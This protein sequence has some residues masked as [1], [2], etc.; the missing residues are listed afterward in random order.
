MNEPSHRLDSSPFSGTAGG[1]AMAT[2]ERPELHPHS[3]FQAAERRKRMRFPLSMGHRKAALIAADFALL[4][5]SLLI[6]IQLAL[7]FGRTQIDANPDPFVVGWY[8]II[9]LAVGSATDIYNPNRITN[10][11]DN[12]VNVTKALLITSAAYFLLPLPTNSLLPRAAVL[13]ATLVAVILLGSWR[14]LVPALVGI[15]NFRRRVIIVGAGTS[16]RMIARVIKT[17]PGCDIVGFVDDDPSKRIGKVEGLAVLGGHGD[18]VRVAAEKDASEIV[19]AINGPMRAELVQSVLTCAEWGIPVLQMQETFEQITGRIPVEHVGDRW[20]V[21]LPINRDMRTAYHFT[22][23][24][25]DLLVSLIGI[26]L[27]APLFPFVAAAIKLDS[28]GPIFYKQLRLGLQGRPFYVWKLRTMIDNAEEKT[29]P[30]FAQKK[31]WRVTRV[32]RFLR[33]SHLDE[34]PQ[35][36]NILKGEMSL[37]GPRP[38]RDF[39]EFER[40]IPFYRARYAAKPGAAGWAL[41]NQGYVDGPEGTLIK[42]QYDLYYIKHQSLYM[43]V[44]IVAK[45]LAEILS[46]RGR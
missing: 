14:A 34:L 46:L 2:G 16:G 23:R 45:T 37:I 26:I 19:L 40:Q 42:L 9:W 17:D 32:G 21:Y 22:K 44:R 30:A 38:E 12:A 25:I 11:V 15:Q 4:S 13:P 35:F 39:P 6:G 20:A 33:A 36:I 28:K 5:L 27:L 31:D 1:P 10:R 29:G 41:V 7:F 43:D 3:T 24:G 18:L 8:L